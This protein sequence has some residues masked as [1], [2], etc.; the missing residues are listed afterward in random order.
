VV[1]PEVEVLRTTACWIEE[2]ENMKRSSG[3]ARTSGTA[4]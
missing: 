3:T 1:V 2:E 4:G